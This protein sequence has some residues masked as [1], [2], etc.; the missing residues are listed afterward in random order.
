MR[1]AVIALF[2]VLVLGLIGAAANQ[3]YFHTSEPAAPAQQGWL[4]QKLEAI[5][6]PAGSPPAISPSSA[7]T[8]SSSAA[9]G[10]AVGGLVATSSNPA[11]S[12]SPLVPLSGTWPRR[13]VLTAFLGA[14]P[15]ARTDVVAKT[16]VTLWVLSMKSQADPRAKPHK[17]YI[18]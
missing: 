1:L 13:S 5:T 4:A 11:Q 3:L 8:N 16:A 18:L 10:T 17:I 6:A 14:A 2:S 7:A 12:A 15:Q 9:V